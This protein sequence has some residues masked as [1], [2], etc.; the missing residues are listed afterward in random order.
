MTDDIR[1][2][3]ASGRWFDAA[4]DS[5]AVDRA[6]ATQVLRRY[7]TDPDLTDDQRTE[8]L[9]NLFGSF[10]AHSAIATGVQVDYGYNIHIGDRCFFNFNC[11]FLD[12][13]P[14]KIGDDAW[15]APHVAFVTPSHPLIAAERNMQFDA[16]GNTHLWEKNN[17]ITIGNG[18]WIA[19][20]VTVNPGVTI[21]DGAVIGS[22]SVVTKDVPPYTLAYG[23]P[24]K[25]IRELTEQDREGLSFDL[26]S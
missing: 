10:G 9:R 16:Q 24:C 3:M 13:A 20:H 21:G 17:A 15:V 1:T 12:G 5:L 18:V 22:G 8:L 23:V 2:E 6:H 26:L 19:S 4:D 25:P 11:V 14:I 7:N